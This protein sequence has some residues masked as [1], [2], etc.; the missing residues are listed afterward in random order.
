MSETIK[1]KQPTATNF[2]IIEGLRTRDLIGRLSKLDNDERDNLINEA[3]TILSNCVN[4]INTI[5]STTGIAVGYVQSGKTMSFTTLTA[6]AIDN[7]FRI[8]IYFA[9]IKNNLLEQTT[10]RL[11]KDL[12]TESDNSKFF[13]VYQ[14]PTV[15]E[16]THSKISRNLNLAHKP[17]ILITLLKRFD[18]ID[19][20]TKIFKSTEVRDALGNNGVLIIDDE[21]DQASLNT[22]ARKNSKSEDWEDDEFSTTYASILNLKA[23]LSNHSYIQYTAT[24]QGPLLINI[25]DLLSP[26]FHVVLTPGKAY[27]G[28]KTF[29]IDNTD[30]IVTIPDAEVYH[31]KYNQL[32][33]C[34]QSLKNALQ[35]FLMGVAINVNIN[36]TENFLSMMIHADSQ[37][38][39]SKKFFDWVKKLISSY[40]E[41]F[42]LDD[43]DP[44]KVELTN[45]FKENYGEAIRRVKNPPTFELVIKEVL[46]VILDTNMEL[47]IQGSREIDWSNASSHILIG[48]DMLNRGYTVE[49]LTVSYMPR[50]SIGKSNADTI[51]QRCR[52]FGYKLNY[53]DSCR[54]FLPNESIMEYRD[55]IEHEEI[56]RTKLKENTLE[57]LEQLLILSSA[58]NPTRNNILSKDVVQHKL[59]GMR[60]MNALQNIEA[61]TDYVNDFI[62]KQ[63]FTNY[64]DYKTPAR[65]HRYVKLDIK[66]VVEFLKDFKIM[67]MPDALRKSS[68]IQYLRYLADKKQ[69]KYAYIFEMGYA[70]K[71][72]DKKGTELIKNNGIVKLNNIFS[73]PSNSGQ[74]PYPGD[75]KIHFEDSLCIQIHHIKIKDDSSS[76]VWGNKKLYTLGI[77]YPEDLAHSFVGVEK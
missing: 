52:F 15:E 11:K 55:Y 49:G 7:G 50:Y 29:F 4:P 20:L 62:A 6:L 38:D 47:V 37:T 27:T 17:A 5:G 74:T 14:S 10:K 54:V 33:D 18:S 67:N 46:Q 61:N 48:A 30:L 75:R 41:R 24:P 64:T 73:G 32:T 28:G 25:M 51:Q 21:A 34:P 72:E 39:A 36:G 77:Y 53:L 43:G 58:M 68:T 60:Q 16:S 13:K 35:L 56:M 40:A 59:S 26:K 45:Q 8:I 65:N 31:H 70:Y 44:S 19:A 76:V 42:N 71:I 22:Y 1:I 57:E 66:N 9:G 2:P 63:T 3:R 69:I 12:L 23:S